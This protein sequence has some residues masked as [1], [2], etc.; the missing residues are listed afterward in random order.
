MMGKGKI[1]F[2]LTHSLKLALTTSLWMNRFGSDRVSP[3][4]LNGK[5]LM[6]FTAWP[7]RPYQ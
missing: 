1:A 7:P 3:A 2:L 5:Y 4:M 6:P